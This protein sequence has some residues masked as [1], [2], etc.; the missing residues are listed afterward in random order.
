[1]IDLGRDRGATETCGASALVE[2]LKTANTTGVPALIEQLRSYRRWA[3]RPLSGLLASTENDRDQHL[4]AS[5]ANLAL[6]PDDG[7]QA[8]YLYDRLLS[9]SPVELPVIWGILRKRHQGI[10]KRLWQL[11]DDPKSDPEKRFHA[12]CALADADSAQVEKSWDTVAPFI[13]DR[14][15]TAAIK[16]PGDYSP[17]IETLRP[18][19]QHL[20][21]PL[22][23][24]FRNTER[25]E[26]ERTFATTIL[27]DYASDDPNRLAE[28]LMAADTKAYVSLFPV[29]EKRAEQVLPVLQ[30]ELARKATYSWNDPPLDPSWTKPDAALVSRI[31]SAQGILAERFAFCQTMPIDDFLTTAEAL[32]KSGY[33]PVRFRP[34]ADGQTVRVAAV[35]TRDGRNWRI[36]SGLTA[37]EV[38][39]EDEP[40][41]ERQVPP[42]RCRRVHDDREGSASPLT[43]MQPS[44]S[45]N[46]AMMTPGCTL[47]RPLM[48]RTKF[49]KNSKRRS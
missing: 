15:L 28:L 30:A 39:Q 22:A 14:F 27:A 9:A 43:A 37:E 31:E 11:L 45:R 46:P 47:G 19:R 10:D 48:S 32:R 21:T 16:N 4:R 13:T 25:S 7:S 49:R 18:I 12:A 41:S 44:G 35:W 26:S 20:L 33:R 6:L 17:L 38:R 42:R 24:I 1:M 8:D 23:L 5:L 40:E 34:Y 3:G 29:A 2:S 36:S